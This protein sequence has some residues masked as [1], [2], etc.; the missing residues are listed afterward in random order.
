MNK[1]KSPGIIAAIII[2]VV[3]LAVGVGVWNAKDSTDNS[4]KTSQQS[5]DLNK[6]TGYVKVNGID[7]YYE[8]YGQKDDQP[9]V[10]LLHGSLQSV[11]VFS[12]VIPTLAK[13]RY[14]VGMDMRGHGHTADVDDTPLSY[15]VMADDVA[16]FLKQKQIA[17]ADFF[18][19]S[20]GGMTAT[21]IALRHPDLVHKTAVIGSSYKSFKDAMYPAV[22]QEHMATL[23][24]GFAVKQFKEPYEKTSP[25]PEK[26]DQLVAKTRDQID[27]NKWPTDEQIKNIQTP[28]LVMMG[29]RDGFR[30]DHAV[31]WYKL[32]PKGQLAILPNADHFATESQPQVVLSLL[33]P[34]LNK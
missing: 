4:Q 31:D 5:Q 13:D 21:E 9:P 16:A 7:M 22:Y 18:G 2:V 20:M 1:I 27:L 28:F 17:Q 29:D 14:V 26:W 23:K 34:F 8:T 32:L 25:N 3:A 12:K 6:K 11:A 30:P 19:W 10:V 33:Q 24:P 15:Q